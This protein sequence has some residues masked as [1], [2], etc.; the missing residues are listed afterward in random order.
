MTS[1]L[2]AKPVHLMFAVG[3]GFAAT[4]GIANATPDPPH[5]RYE[6]TGAGVAEYLSYQSNTGQ[7]Q[8]ANVKL[9]WSTEFNSYAGMVY[10][11]SAQGPG[12]LTCRILLNGNVAKEATATGA[13]AR[14]VCSL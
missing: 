8:Q 10:V 4:C 13:P 5:V 14:T 7:S 6:V 12:N 1:P 2:V 11:I 3:I 9:P